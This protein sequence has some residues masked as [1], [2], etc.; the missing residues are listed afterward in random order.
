M[1]QI[2]Q[3]DGNS[4]TKVLPTQSIEEFYRDQHL[5]FISAMQFQVFSQRRGCFVPV[6]QQ[7]SAG[8]SVSTREGRSEGEP[9]PAKNC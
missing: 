2:L 5:V 9:R 8:D 6:K 4:L 3:K 7:Q 1:S